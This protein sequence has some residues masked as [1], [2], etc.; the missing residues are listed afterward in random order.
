MNV[1]LMVILTLSD[2]HGEV[3]LLGCGVTAMLG[4]ILTLSDH[5]DEVDLV[6]C[7]VFDCPV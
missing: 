7:G 6:V 3:D 4:L 1:V 2:H 5:H